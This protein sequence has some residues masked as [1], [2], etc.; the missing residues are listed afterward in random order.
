MSSEQLVDALDRMTRVPGLTGCA[1]VEIE[2]GMVWDTAGQMPDVQ[3]I[4]EAASDYWRLYLRLAPQ[5][6]D[7]G[8]L[9][10]SLMWHAQGQLVLL[11][12]GKGVL[13]VGLAMHDGSVDWPAC[14]EQARE[15]A[16]LVDRL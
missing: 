15:L 16:R 10:G 4:A 8:R 1:L 2:A 9:H 11:P 6:G 12:C 7:L 13:L 3:R 5:F 14:F